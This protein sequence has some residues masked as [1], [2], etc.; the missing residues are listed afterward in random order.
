[1]RRLRSY[2]I[3]VVLVAA[4]TTPIFASCSQSL[5]SE[6]FS[7]TDN[8]FVGPAGGSAARQF[9]LASNCVPGPI[10]VL[11]TALNGTAPQPNDP[12]G[13]LQHDRAG[14]ITVTQ[15]PTVG[16]DSR[17]PGLCT[18]VTAGTVCY[19]Y[20]ISVAA[21][22][23]SGETV[24]LFGSFY[25]R[26]AEFFLTWGDTGQLPSF[27]E[28]RAVAQHMNGNSHLTV[29]N[30]FA[31]YSAL[32]VTLPTLD[33]PS[34]VPLYPP[35][36]SLAADGESA[37]VL[38]YQSKSTQPVIFDL[39]ASG[40]GLPPGA[41]VGSVGQFDANYLVNPNP[42]SCSLPCEVTQAYGPDAAGNYV[43]FALLWAPNSMPVPNVF[44]LVNLTITATQLGSPTEQVSVALEPPPL[45]LIHGVWSSADEAWPLPPASG[46]PGWL[47]P[48][49]P[50]NKIYR[51]D[52]GPQSA[53]AFSDATIQRRLLD[54]MD[55]ALAAAAAQGTVARSVDVVAHSMGGLVTRYFQ[56]QGPPLASPELL[57]NPVHRL[58]TIG[59]PNLGSLLPTTLEN[60]LTA[61]A[62][63][64]SF[65]WL[66]CIAKFISPC[67]LGNFFNSI[68][69]KVDTA[70]VSMEPGSTQLGM[71]N[72]Q[73]PYK[74]V[75]LST[76]PAQ[77]PSQVTEPLLNTIIGGFLPLKTV[78]TILLTND[79][80]TI[81]ST[82]SQSDNDP[83]AITIPG[84]VHANLCGAVY[85][86]NLL[87]P[88]IG[89][90]AS[91]VF[92]AQAYWWLTG[93]GPGTSPTANLIFTGSSKD[94]TTT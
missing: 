89:E 24:Q 43:F 50:P 54:Q 82:S 30:P 25:N 35:A 27:G 92:W 2:C 71:L 17:Y 8:V 36:I 94:L 87:C 62:V 23:N 47:Q 88:D 74:V 42:T 40:T 15:Q 80:D 56:S 19:V 70:L 68:G 12:F 78:E 77:F 57:S 72:V 49:Y 60:N 37:A 85:L 44:P 73:T 34:E 90:T 18:T 21:D 20:S 38:V 3:G 69:K 9:T 5:I 64:G 10:S 45:L 6:F 33:I 46:F 86:P 1:M 81:V 79:H 61:T 52:Y 65:D 31:P 7:G 93:G 58:I 84:I 22:P 48:Q 14:W 76:V 11:E 91:P 53:I 66:V 67:N 63:T 41:T 83:S 51:V 26:V 55:D 32:H 39:S 4:S 16:P 28:G 75:G 13:I 59:T 29:V